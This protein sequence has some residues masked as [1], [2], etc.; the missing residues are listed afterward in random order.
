MFMSVSERT[1]E[2]GI[3]RALG[4][5]KKDIRR[6]FTSESLMIGLS[7]AALAIGL[8]YGLGYVF[9]AA[10]YKIAKFNM[11]QIHASNVISVIVIAIIISFLA[12]LLPAR[13]ASK[14][15]PIDALSAD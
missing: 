4:E 15:N 12:A 11:I 8:G 13:R 3:L 10:L 1:K 14:L 6:L 7:S 5:S 2:I 9:N